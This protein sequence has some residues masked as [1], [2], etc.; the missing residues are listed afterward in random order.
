MKIDI[1]IEVDK[2]STDILQTQLAKI[3][4]HVGELL[5]SF[6]K[7]DLN[8]KDESV[9]ETAASEEPVEVKKSET[10]EPKIEEVAQVKE[11][12]PEEPKAAKKQKTEVKKSKPT[13][14]PSKNTAKP[15]K[16][17][18]TVSGA[19]LNIIKEDKNGVDAPTIRKKTGF[20]AKKVADAVYQ[21]KK[22]GQI[23]KTDKS[24]FVAI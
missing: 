6:G 14:K 11:P 17:K 2:E 15:K 8:V 3:T 4:E 18:A 21:L 13:A 24:L 12:V 1:K 9:Q 23:T 22:K 20:S 19:V 10:S 7:L 5:K 16:Q